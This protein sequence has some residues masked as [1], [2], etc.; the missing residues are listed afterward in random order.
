MRSK[1]RTARQQRLGGGGA[2][3]DRQ[4]RVG[5]VGAGD[6]DVALRGVRAG[7]AEA[8]PRHGLA[9]QAA[10]TADVQQPQ[11]LE[12]RSRRGIP[13]ESRQ[14]LLAYEGQPDRV[15]PMQ[16]R[17]LAMRVPPLLGDGGEP[18]HVGG[19]D[20]GRGGPSVMRDVVN[21][22]GPVNG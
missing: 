21:R 6:G 7:D 3:V 17:E 19:V 5:R 9:E 13:A 16:G 4:A 20:A 15:E 1:A 8:Q 12:R 2:I 10:A 18:R 11:S 22:G 14:R